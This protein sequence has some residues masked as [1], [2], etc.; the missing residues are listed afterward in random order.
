MEGWQRLIPH[1]PSGSIANCARHLKGA[2]QKESAMTTKRRDFM[3]TCM[4][5]CG[6]V[7]AESFLSNGLAATQEK[8][9][10]ANEDL[11]REHGVLRRALLVYGA[12]ADRLMQQPASLPAHALARTA[13]LF[14]TFGED[15]HE[16][17]LEEKIIFP[18]IRKL[19]GPVS[20]YADVLQQH[21]RGRDLTD[22]VLRVAQGGNV[23]GSNAAPLAA[24]L[25]EFNLMYAHHAA[26]E[27][28]VVFTAW[29]N[30]LSQKNYE[31]AGEEFEKI[32]KQV[33][34]HDGFD[35]ASKEIAS[36]EDEMGLSDIGRFTMNKPPENKK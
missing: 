29:K 31:E 33:F 30:S 27:D 22:Y 20:R 4:V 17:R 2:L 5:G 21:D 12:A 19:E 15:Y 14:R 28:T 13:R 9:V 3:E 8:K 25:R 26:R 23:A 24:A 11:M 34:G 36:I 16:R 6:L 32:E 1:F 7:L 35:Y 18:A 10:T